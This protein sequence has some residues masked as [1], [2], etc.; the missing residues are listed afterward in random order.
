MRI[1]KETFLRH[2]RDFAPGAVIF[3]EGE[4]GKEMYIVVDGK[5]EITKSTSGSAAKTLATLGRGDLFGEMAIIDKKARAATATAVGA[6]KVLVLNE[7]LFDATL[8][9]NPDFARK[10]V[11]LLSE[12]LRHTNLLLQTALSTNRQKLV[13][14]ALTQ[15]AAEH[16]SSTFRGTRFNANAFAVWAAQHIGLDEKDIRDHVDALLRRKVLQPSAAG[17]DELLIGHRS[18]PPAGP[19]GPLGGVG[20][21]GGAGRAGPASPSGA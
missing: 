9:H 2:V 4:P 17:K 1:S 8:A 20:P 6:T 13:M 7:A 11:K 3:R 12:R 5:V 18:S 10:I 14:D 21:A 19:A 15:F 16:G